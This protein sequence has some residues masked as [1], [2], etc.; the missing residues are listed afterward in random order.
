MHL[1]KFRSL[2]KTNLYS[3]SLRFEH[4]YVLIAADRFT[5]KRLARSAVEDGDSLTHSLI[6][7]IIHLLPS[8]CVNS[9]FRSDRVLSTIFHDR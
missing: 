7:Y 6:P 2:K 1:M 4:T 9:L 5:I 8:L 3:F